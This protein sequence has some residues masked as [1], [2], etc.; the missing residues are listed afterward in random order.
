[1]IVQHVGALEQPTGHEST[2]FPIEASPKRCSSWS[3]GVARTGIVCGHGVYSYADRNFVV[4][5]DLEFL[6]K[7][8]EMSRSVCTTIQSA[9]SRQSTHG[10]RFFAAFLLWLLQH[11]INH[12]TNP[13]A[14]IRLLCIGILTAMSLLP[15]RLP[16]EIPKII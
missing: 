16:D 4:D 2:H 13:A 6:L 11:F 12:N 10:I 3:R 5:A 7:E 1:M 15:S 14:P 8:V 9:A